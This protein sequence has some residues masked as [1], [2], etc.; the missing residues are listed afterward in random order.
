[1]TGHRWKVGDA[2][3]FGSR[4]YPDQADRVTV[5]SVTPT[6]R[7]R[8][9]RDRFLPDGEPEGGGQRRLYSAKGWADLVAR[10][11]LC[12]RLEALR[13]ALPSGNEWEAM[14]ETE[15]VAWERRM[16]VRE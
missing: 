3:V 8:V 6:G 15:R 11:A 16:G 13:T 14:D 2:A 7:P 1:M 4:W 12:D 10:L 5:T 9:G